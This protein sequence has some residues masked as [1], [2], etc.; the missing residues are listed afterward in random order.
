M[1]NN[2][3]GMNSKTRSGLV[4]RL[5]HHSFNDGG[6]P[7]IAIGGQRRIKYFLDSPYA[8]SKGIAGDIYIKD[9]LVQ[10]FP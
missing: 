4:P 8:L 2:Q 1:L 6:S 10:F 7:P 5:V 3:N 9:H